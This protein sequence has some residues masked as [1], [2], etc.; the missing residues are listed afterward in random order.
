VRAESLVEAMNEMGVQAIAPS[1]RDFA[2]G[3]AEMQKL[4]QRAKFPFLS[5]NLYSKATG[6]PLFP[7]YLEIKTAAGPIVI[8]GVASAETDGHPASEAIEVRPPTK[9]LVDAISKIKAKARLVIVLSSLSETEREAARRD[10]PGVTLLLGGDEADAGADPV[11]LGGR[12]LYLNPHSAGKAIVEAT[13][14]LQGNTTAFFNPSL[15]SAYRD[16]L[17]RWKARLA[18]IESQLKD[19]KLEPATREALL[20]ERTNYA[21]LVAQGSDTPLDTGPGITRY[22][23]KFLDLDATY[24]SPNA[25]T[26][27]VKRYKNAVREMASKGEF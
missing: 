6:R 4:E 16:N 23:A 27:I 9:A 24:A 7:S 21:D 19:P 26:D 14:E 2:L 25:L 12:F 10:L 13:L 3:D 1:A 17:P 5:V 22:D 8:L 18:N 15:S 20:D 11:Q